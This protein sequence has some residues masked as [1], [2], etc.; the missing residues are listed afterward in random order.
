M[1]QLHH[2]RGVITT[3]RDHLLSS[4][5]LMAKQHEALG[6]THA[7]IVQFRNQAASRL[8]SLHNEVTSGQ[9]KI[10]CCLLDNV[11]VLREMGASEVALTDLMAAISRDGRDGTAEVSLPPMNPIQHRAVVPP[12]DIQIEMNHIIS[13]QGEGESNQDFERRAM[14]TI[15][16]K[17]RASAAFPIPKPKANDEPIRRTGSD[18][19][20]NLPQHPGPQHPIE[21]IGSISTAI[22]SRDV[23]FGSLPATRAPAT[24]FAGLSQNASG[25]QSMGGL[26]ETAVTVFDEFTR[27]MAKV[28]RRIIDR[29]LGQT[30]TLPNHIRPPKV[31]PPGKYAGADNHGVFIQFLERVCTWMRSQ[32]ITGPETDAYRITLLSGQLE[33]YALEWITELMES[34]NDGSNSEPPFELT[35]TNVFC[36]MHRRFVTSADA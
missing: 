2:F 22:R 36:E 7:G 19:H 20:L 18:T 15:R 27:D 28:I 6:N 35:F 12:A 32:L 21:D 11:K 16:R 17:E 34:Y 13:P 5:V 25:F 33:G 14:A 26:E 30:L 23:R 10:N 31:D 9:S 8:A 3:S 24:S 1:A 4:T 29:N